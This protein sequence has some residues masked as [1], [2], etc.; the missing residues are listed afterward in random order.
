MRKFFAGALVMVALIIAGVLIW[1][2][3]NDQAQGLVLGFG[4][5]AVGLGAGVVI[6]L[7]FV[8]IVFLL[9]L[10]YDASPRYPTPQPPII[11][12]GGVV[13]GLE[14]G[15]PVYPA[16]PLAQRRTQR[17]WQNIGGEDAPPPRGPW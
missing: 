8:G 1:Y 15:T 14:A 7:A 6:A 16:P 9:R 3:L 2:G 12:Q 13:P 17:N 4:M 5:G 11:I 10:R